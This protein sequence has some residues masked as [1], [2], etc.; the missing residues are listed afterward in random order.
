MTKTIYKVQASYHGEKTPM[1][2]TT[3]DNLADAITAYNEQKERAT[4]CNLVKVEMELLMGDAGKDE[5]DT[6]RFAK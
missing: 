3:Y 5:S 4:F 2:A 6:F 1:V